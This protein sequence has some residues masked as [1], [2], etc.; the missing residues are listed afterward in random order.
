MASGVGRGRL[1]GHW[2]DVDR[3]DRREPEAH[4]R[5]CENA[6]AAADVEEGAALGGRREELDAEPRRRMRTGAE[7]AAGV[8]HDR[9]SGIGCL[10]PGRPNPEPADG[11]RVMEAPPRVLPSPRHR[12][13]HG[14]REL[15]EER[16]DVRNRNVGRELD[17]VAVHDL[18]EPGRHK[19]EKPRPDRL[20]LV[21]EG[22][23]GEAPE[24]AHAAPSNGN[25]V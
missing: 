15:T 16:I 24:V 2:I 3:G 7:R 1:D 9:A 13:H 11:D 23:D 19:L 6:G 20:D 14:I 21:A 12:L 25:R 17:H 10:L 8:D 4:A 5:D 18:L 22:A